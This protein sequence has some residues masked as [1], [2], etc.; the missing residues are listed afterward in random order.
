MSHSYIEL[1]QLFD[2]T[3]YQTHNVRLIRGDDE[4]I[5]LPADSVIPFNRIV[6]AHGFYR[7]A[8]HEISHW[9]VAGADRRKQVDYG[10]WYVSDGRNQEQQTAFEQVEI[11]PQAIEWALSVAAGCKFEVSC[12]NLDGTTPDRHQF[13]RRVLQQV[14]SFLASGFPQ[15]AAQFIEVLAKHYQTR[16]PL[17][18]NSFA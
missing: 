7:S 13:S 14:E 6:F 11:I 15:R 16:F 18:I 9:C 4:P 10:Y 17:S 3:F 1:M 5:Y 8:L 12:D 2:S